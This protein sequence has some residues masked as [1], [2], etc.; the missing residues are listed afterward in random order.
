M[1]TKIP[2]PRRSGAINDAK[3]PH[4]GARARR[5]DTARG[6]GAVAETKEAQLRLRPSTRELALAL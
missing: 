2:T 3:Q 5:S 4:A 6:I 1:R